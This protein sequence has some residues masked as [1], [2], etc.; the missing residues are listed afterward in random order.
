MACEMFGS[1]LPVNPTIKLGIANASRHGHVVIAECL[2][3]LLDAPML[4]RVKKVHR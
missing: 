1:P 4:V 3:L 2:H